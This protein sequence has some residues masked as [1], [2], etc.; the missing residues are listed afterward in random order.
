MASASASD[1]VA[2]AVRVWFVPGVAVLSDTVADGGVFAIVT[3]SAVTSV[4]V[5]PLPSCAVTFTA[6]TWFLPPLPGRLRSS[7]DPV[8]P[9]MST[10]SFVHW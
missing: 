9:A 3:P 10:P 5:P 2:V 1:L 4:E 6:I 8:W 7:E